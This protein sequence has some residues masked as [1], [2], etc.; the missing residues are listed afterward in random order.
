[1]IILASIIVAVGIIGYFTFQ[2]YATPQNI[3]NEANKIIMNTENKIQQISPQLTNLSSSQNKPFP[4]TSEDNRVPIVVYDNCQSFIRSDLKTIDTTC[5]LPLPTYQ[6]TFKF[7][8]PD[9]LE[10]KIQPAALFNVKTKVYQ[11]GTTDFKIGLY[12]QTGEKNYTVTLAISS[13]M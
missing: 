13:I 7:D 9:V 3:Q 11:Y 6:K 10:Q 8:V 12:D 4:L 1:M 2:T 5:K